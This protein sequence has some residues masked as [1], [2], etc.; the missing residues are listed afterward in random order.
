MNHPDTSNLKFGMQPRWKWEK[1]LNILDGK[2]SWFRRCC[3]NKHCLKL[4]LVLPTLL[5]LFVPHESQKKPKNL[6]GCSLKLLE[7]FLSQVPKN[8]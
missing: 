7:G 5:D 6:P 8:D 1:D 2:S 4:G 3:Q